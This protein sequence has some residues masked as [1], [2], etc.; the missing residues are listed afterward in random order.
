MAIPS[1][2]SNNSDVEVNLILDTFKLTSNFLK[3]SVGVDGNEF[4]FG[5]GD[6]GGK[7]GS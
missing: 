5:A 1:C 3:L 7:E 2:N 6:E 4:E